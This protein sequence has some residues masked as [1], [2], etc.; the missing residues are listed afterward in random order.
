MQPHFLVGTAFHIDVHAPGEGSGRQLLHHADGGEQKRD[1]HI[2]DGLP[3]VTQDRAKA[4]G[5]S[6]EGHGFSDSVPLVLYRGNKTEKHRDGDDRPDRQMH[7]CQCR[8]ELTDAGRLH[9]QQDAHDRR[10]RV[11]D[12]GGEDRYDEDHHGGRTACVIHRL[13]DIQ[14]DGEQQKCFQRCPWLSVQR[15]HGADDAHS[16]R[17][18]DVQDRDRAGSEHDDEHQYDIDRPECACVDEVSGAELSV[19]DLCCL[20]DFFS[21]HDMILLFDNVKQQAIVKHRASQ[22]PAFCIKSACAAFTG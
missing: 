20:G 21:C 12:Q 16:E 13:L 19:A 15:Q 3:R 5:Y 22:A 17:S 18:D 2:F 4:Q 1:Q 10:Q 6:P 14:S 9:D 11:E 7:R 8:E